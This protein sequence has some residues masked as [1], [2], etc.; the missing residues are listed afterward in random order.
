MPLVAEGPL[1]LCVWAPGNRAAQQ[2]TNG[3]AAIVLQRLPR[4][5]VRWA[6]A[7]E[8]PA[9]C[10]VRLQWE[11]EANEPTPVVGPVA[12]GAELVRDARLGGALPWRL[13]DGRAEL[14]AE[15]GQRLRVRFVLDRDGRKSAPFA[16]LPAELDPATFVD[17]QEIGLRATA[18]AVAAAI[19]QVAKK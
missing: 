18:A 15:P 1:E 11:R 19:E 13:V 14:S 7:P 12:R 17:G 6:D 8:L 3:D 2:T 4:V 5:T 10:T 16:V 9:A